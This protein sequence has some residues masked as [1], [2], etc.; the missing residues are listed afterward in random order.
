MLKTKVCGMKFPE[1]IEQIALL[2]PDFLGFIFYEKSKR[3]VG[4]DFN[5]DFLKIIPKNIS[6]TG[7]FVNADFEYILQKKE[8]YQL[9]YIQL[10]GDESAEFC[11]ELKNE[12]CKIIKA[13]G[14][15]ENF[16]F[17]VTDKYTS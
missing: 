13:F 6:K 2:N 16:D 11:C 15:N 14:V 3:F 4:E 5:I 7:V 17:S 9:D 8:K 1:N 12:N 10:H